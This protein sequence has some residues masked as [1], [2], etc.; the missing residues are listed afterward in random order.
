M[1]YIRWQPPTRMWN[2]QR[3][4]LWM[5]TSFQR[6]LYYALF[7]LSVHL[8]LLGWVFSGPYY[9]REWESRWG[10]ENVIFYLMLNVQFGGHVALLWENWKSIYV[11]TVLCVWTFT[12]LMWNQRHCFE[13]NFG[14]FT[15]QL[16]SIPSV[17]SNTFRPSFPPYV[18]ISLLEPE[19]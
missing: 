5:F 6:G 9:H 19:R 8:T 12:L 15:P 14:V 17:Y 2:L 18:Y 13:S 7:I 10:I 1:L 4:L 11:S 16:K 3:R